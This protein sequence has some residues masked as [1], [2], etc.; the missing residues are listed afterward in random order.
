[1]GL[2][3]AFHVLFFPLSVALFIIGL[4]TS[5]LLV[6]YAGMALL[7]AVNVT[8]AVCDLSK[9]SVFLFFHL[10]L[11]L[12]LISRPTI[13][14][15]EGGV[16]TELSLDFNG[17]LFS[18]AVI[19]LSMFFLRLGSGAAE[20]RQHNRDEKAETFV[21]RHPKD[22]RKNPILPTL[23]GA[24]AIVYGIGFIGLM[25]LGILKL[26]AMQGLSYEHFYLVSISEYTN[27]IVRTIATMEPYALCAFLATFPKKRPA[28][29]VLIMHIITTIP[30]LIIGSR[31]DFVLGVLFLMLYYVLRNF[32]DGKGS[33]IGHFERVLVAICLPVGIIAMGMVSV[34]RSSAQ[35]INFSLFDSLVTAIYQQGVTYE[36]LSKGYAV[37]DVIAAMGFKG[38]SF[39]ALT[40]Y[41]LQGP[42]G[43]YILGNSDL[44]S[45]NSI[46]LAVQGH[47]YAHT[48]SYFM[49][50]RYLQGAGWGSSYL[51][52]L[53]QDFGMLGVGIFSFLFG[54]ILSYLPRLLKRSWLTGTLTLTVCIVIFH[55]PRGT[56]IEWISY[57]W[58][59]QFWFTLTLIGGL[60][61]VMRSKRFAGLITAC[62]NWLGGTP[63][64]TLRDIRAREPWN[65]QLQPLRKVMNTDHEHDN[66]RRPMGDVQA[67][68]RLH[69]AHHSLL[70]WLGGGSELAQIREGACNQ[71]HS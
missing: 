28:T 35:I 48:M 18:L 30:V 52:E 64:E 42:F 44:G 56:A 10:G 71:L 67:S 34:I 53:Y 16:L 9:R 50:W 45:A 39:G 47:S 6:I 37:R 7:F 68:H 33:W 23:R 13:K 17:A 24:S 36:V 49:H 43:I 14:L 62:R 38:F 61:Y 25:W 26:Q 63:F 41:I 4:I 3:R 21:D 20:W 40:D 8:Y 70:R 12:F 32:I 65:R 54:M 58:T 57:V 27:V 1:M 59:L 55:M 2:V 46:N 19:F 29:I 22:V 51:L 15:L 31:A 60:A 11:A 69:P 66:I 5:D